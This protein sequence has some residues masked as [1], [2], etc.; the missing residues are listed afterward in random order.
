MYRVGHKRER[1]LQVS[2]K[3]AAINERER[4]RERERKGEE[5]NKQLNNT[6]VATTSTELD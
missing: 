2:Y 1:E 3:C 6:H 5:E 4:E